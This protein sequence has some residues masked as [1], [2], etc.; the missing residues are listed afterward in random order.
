MVLWRTGAFDRHGRLRKQCCTATG[1]RFQN[2]PSVLYRIRRIVAAHTIAANGALK[3]FDGIPIHHQT[4]T[5]NEKIVGDFAASGEA[6]PFRNRV[7]AGRRILDPFDP[8]GDQSGFVP[9]G[10]LEAAD[11]ATDQRKS[12]LI[13]VI[14]RRFDDANI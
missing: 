11:A 12:R 4:G 9:A 6:D 5:N 1:K 14:L 10:L 13:V 7:D 3:A 8:V 2:F